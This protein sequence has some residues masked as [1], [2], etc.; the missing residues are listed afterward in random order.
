MQKIKQFFVSIKNPFKNFSFSLS[1]MKKVVLTTVATSVAVFLICFGIVYANRG[2]VFTWF[3]KQYVAD[4]EKIAIDSTKEKGDDKSSAPVLFSQDGLVTDAVKKTNPAVV[5]IVISKNVPKY[6]TYYDQQQNPF[7]D[8][9]GNG[10]DPFGGLFPNFVIPQQRQNGTEKKEVGGGSGFLVSSN[11]Y[12][13]TNKHVVDDKTAEYTVFLNDGRK[14]TATVVARDP[15]LDI[16][17]IKIDGTGYPF[18]D[19]GTSSSLSLGQS[20]IAIGNA[21]GQFKNTVSVGVISGLS[22]SITAGDG[23][24]KSEQLDNIIQTDA[25]INPG[26]SGGPLLNLRGQ[27]IGVNVAVAQGSQSIGFALPID[28]VKGVIDSVKATGKIVRPYI[29]IRY[30]QITPELKDKNNLSVD[31]G[32]LVKGGTDQNELAVIPGSPADKAGI[33]E[34][35]ILLEVDGKKLDDTLNLS[36][37]VRGK[38]IGDTITLKILHRGEEKTV[39]VKLASAPQS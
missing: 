10:T 29:G 21:L 23:M 12:I 35:D 15:V 39:Q 1:P 34:N 8:I 17:V 5:S 27:V 7:G 22:R 11:G 28:S 2:R 3:A 13:V 19:L 32:L 31:Y 4:S 25:A 18:L 30:T 14:K 36:T 38:N 33:V 9:F 20:V 24:G 37:Y 26:N 6:E 16:A